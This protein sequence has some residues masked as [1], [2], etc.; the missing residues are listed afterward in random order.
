MTITHMGGT[1]MRADGPDTLIVN[2]FPPPPVGTEWF[3]FLA[4]HD[5]TQQF[6][7]DYLDEGAFQ[8]IGGSLARPRG[9]RERLAA[10]DADALA[11][12]LRRGGIMPPSLQFPAP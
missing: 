11:E 12:A 6:R 5:Q 9:S 10:P 2:G 7:I 1:I 4:W 8:V 3:M